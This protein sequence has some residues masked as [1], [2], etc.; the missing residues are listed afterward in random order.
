[1]RPQEPKKDETPPDDLPFVNDEC[2]DYMWE[3]ALKKFE[4]NEKKKAANEEAKHEKP[5]EQ[6]PPKA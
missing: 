6:D 2:G 4:E 3:E 1:M 5:R